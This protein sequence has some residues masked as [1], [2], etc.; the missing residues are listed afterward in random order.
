MWIPGLPE[1]RGREEDLQ[2]EEEEEEE[3]YAE[4]EEKDGKIMCLLCMSEWRL[5]VW[6]T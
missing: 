2:E 5:E 4:E 1:V 3:E 6:E